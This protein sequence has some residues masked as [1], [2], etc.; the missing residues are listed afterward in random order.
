MKNEK[1][2]YPKEV[3]TATMADADELLALMRLA[4]TEQ[5][6]APFSEDAVRVTIK[7]AIEGTENRKGVIGV[8]EGERGIEG[9]ILAF[10][11]PW[12]FS[13]PAVPEGWRLEELTNFV[14]PDCR[15]S[16]H[17][18]R[19][20]EFAKWLSENIGLILIMG[21]MTNGRLDAKIRLYQRQVTPFGGLF[22]HNAA[23]GCSLSE[24]G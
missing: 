22:F 7:S 8:V 20:I 16:G 11:T 2:E 24:M 6:I 17:A 13:D 12:W 5:P 1:T 14:H 4:H 21:I 10:I 23:A 15:R 19:L 3:R 18:K 9:Y